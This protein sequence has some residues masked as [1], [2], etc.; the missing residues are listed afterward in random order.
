MPPMVS[1]DDFVCNLPTNVNDSELFEEMSE[2]PISRSTCEWTDSIC[3]H[4]LA[5]TLP[6]RLKA[7]RYMSNT[8]ADIKYEE[9][10]KH[11]R[12]LEKI[13]QE[14]P[15]PLRF[16]HVS[17][18]ASCQP[19]RLFARMTF[20][21]FIRRVLLNLYTPFAFAIPIDDSFKEMRVSYIQSCLVLL[22]YQDIFDPKFS[23]LEM[24]KAEGYW[25]TF[26]KLYKHDV[27]QTCLGVCIEIK[28][29]N[30]ASSASSARVSANSGL[31]PVPDYA[32]T[33]SS[34]V[35]PWT[36]ASLIKT[37][38]DTI[39]P[40]VRR[41]ARPGSDA[42]DLVCLAVVLHSLRP[43]HSSDH[44]ELLI[45]EGVTELIQACQRQLQRDGVVIPSPTLT[46]CSEAPDGLPNTQFDFSGLADVAQFD[47]E[48]ASFP[49]MSFSG[50]TDNNNSV[51]WNYA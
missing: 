46:T 16:D 2:L 39:E 18:Q 3:Q 21:I 40:M 15:A 50:N 13:L 26:Y 27:V 49:D 12:G 6:Q 22:C 8:N 35:Q 23:E 51:S 5:S 10:L 7:Y 4:V 9:V 30:R 1:S 38:E 37:V 44:R 19:G 14:L 28:R 32:D 48:M 31:T 34:K 41:V 43:S 36:K 24:P 29:L 25:D 20:D 42:K 17:G 45:K 47:L 33:V 11:T